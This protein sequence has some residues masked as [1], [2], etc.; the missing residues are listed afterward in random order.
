MKSSA[1]LSWYGFVVGTRMRWKVT[2]RQR[3]TYVLSLALI[4]GCSFCVSES[5]CQNLC[6]LRPEFGMLRNFR[7]APRVYSKPKTKDLQGRRPRTSMIEPVVV[8]NNNLCKY[9]RK[10]VR[11]MLPPKIADR[12]TIMQVTNVSRIF[13]FLLSTIPLCCVVSARSCPKFAMSGRI[14]PPSQKG[15]VHRQ[16]CVDKNTG[17]N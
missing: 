16:S 8:Q 11:Q 2:Q 6:W 15:F 17:R 1:V 7:G 13:V 14:G 4:K 9:F 3:H 12:S 5:V 10:R